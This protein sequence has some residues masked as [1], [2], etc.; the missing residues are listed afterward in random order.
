MGYL[1]YLLDGWLFKSEQY[2]F[3]PSDSPDTLLFYYYLLVLFYSILYWF[4][5]LLAYYANPESFR[6][7]AFAL[8]QRDWNN[9]SKC[10]LSGIH[11]QSYTNP[12]FRYNYSTPFQFFPLLHHILLYSCPRPLNDVTRRLASEAA[13]EEGRW[14]WPVFRSGA[15]GGGGD[16]AAASAAAAV[17]SL[18]QHRL[19]G[20]V[21]WMWMSSITS[22]G[23]VDGYTDAAT[24]PVASAGA[25]FLGRSVGFPASFFFFA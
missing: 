11:S 24:P 17:A 15:A 13:A 12:P 18:R 22:L 4:K 9:S 10:L 14:A 23:N 16:V 3:H 8:W 6:I 20:F 5:Q 25:S 2:L 21:L 7:V 19:P 1:F